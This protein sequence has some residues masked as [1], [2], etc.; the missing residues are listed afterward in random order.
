ME[1]LLVKG[2]MW[3]F[4]LKNGR[5]TLIN[6]VCKR[7]NDSPYAEKN[8]CIFSEN[9]VG[10]SWKRRTWFS[11]GTNAPYRPLS[12]HTEHFATR[13]EAST[14]DAGPFSQLG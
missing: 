13:Q 3:F 4:L 2:K 5:E 7:I 14:Q 10:V 12:D 9:H 1:C 6:H 11:V 8:T